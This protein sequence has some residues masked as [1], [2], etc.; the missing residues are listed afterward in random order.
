MYANK[1]F[2]VLELSDPY[3]KPLHIGK[4]LVKTRVIVV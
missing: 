4:D 2:Y 1:V 3:V